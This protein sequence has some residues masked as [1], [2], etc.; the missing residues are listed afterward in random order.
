MMSLVLLDNFVFF[1]VNGIEYADKRD[2]YI[3]M[4]VRACVREYADIIHSKREIC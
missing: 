1:H 2:V 4:F 3:K